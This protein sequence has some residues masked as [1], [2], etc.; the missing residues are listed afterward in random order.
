MK[1]QRLQK[2]SFLPPIM[3]PQHQQKVK[4]KYNA[5]V[6]DAADPEEGP[7]FGTSP[8]RTK[9][10]NPVKEMPINYFNKQPDKSS[11]FSCEDED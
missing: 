3:E 1:K 2:Q 6:D 8:E 11:D 10:W 9:G 5:I 4:S 7:T